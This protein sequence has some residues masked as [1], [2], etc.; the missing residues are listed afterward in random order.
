VVVFVKNRLPG[1][2]GKEMIKE[3]KGNEFALRLAAAIMDLKSS[4]AYFIFQKAYGE[5]SWEEVEEICNE[6]INT[7]TCKKCK[8]TLK[9]VREMFNS[10]GGMK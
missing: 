1:K 4:H 3:C 5:I 2:T 9:E 7:C 8:K 10:K 6:V